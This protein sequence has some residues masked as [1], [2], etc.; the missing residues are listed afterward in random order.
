[1]TGAA[2]GIGRATA[3]LMLARGDEVIA[4]DRDM[5]AL[6]SLAGAVALAG[7]VTNDE[8]NAAMVAEALERFGRLDTVVLNAGIAHVGPLDAADDGLFGRLLDVNV[9]GVASGLRAA[10]PA[11]TASSAPAVV[12]V[13]SISGLGGEP[14]MAL[15]SATKGAVI[16][17]TRSAAVELGARGVRI[18]CVCP[19][20]TITGLTRPTLE[21]DPRVGERMARFVPL[22]RLAEPEEI[23]EVIAFLASP[24]ASYVH[25]AIVPVDGGI[26]ANAGQQRPP[27]APIAGSLAAT[28][29]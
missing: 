19:G 7:D 15:Y 6:A 5:G 11:L 22:K 26:T 29:A 16:S 4:V 10:L 25:G 17:L 27:D 14:F 21:S 2:S 18:N 23:A 28:P 3:E 8:D 24:A 13:A 20:P 12:T 9:R 1:M